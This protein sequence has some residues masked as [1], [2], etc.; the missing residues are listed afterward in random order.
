MPALFGS[1]LSS[2]HSLRYFFT[3]PIQASFYSILGLAQGKYARSAHERR[4]TVERLGPPFEEAV[5]TGASIRLLALFFVLFPLVA[6]GQS[7]SVSQNTGKTAGSHASAHQLE[8]KDYEQF[9]PYWT[10]EGS[11]LSELHLRNNLNAQD[12]V[13]TPSIRLAEG[14]EIG[15]QAVTIKPQEVK[16]IDVGTAAPQVGKAYGSIV[17]RYHSAFSDSVYASL[18]LHDLGH[19][20]AIHLDAIHA[21]ET[22]QGVS[23]E[24]VWWLPNETTNDYLVLTNQGSNPFKLDL[25]IYDAQGKESK[26]ALAL[27][28]RQTTRYSVRQLVQSAGFRG[29]YGGI[30]VVA[31]THAGSLDTVHFLFDE[32]AAFSALMKMFDQDPAAKIESRDFAR[33]GVWTQRA[34]MLALSQPDPALGFPAGTILQPQIFVRN[35]TSKPVTAALRFNW[36]SQSASGKATGPTLQLAPFETRQIDIAALQDGNGLPKEANWTSVTL[37]TKGK[38]DDLVAVAAS[39]DAT[40]LYGAQTPFSDQLSFRWEGGLWQYDAQHDSIITAGNGGTKPTQTAFTIFYNQGKDKYALEQ[41]LQPDEQMWIDVGKLIRERVLD[42]NGNTLPVDLAS[43]SYEFRDLNDPGVGSLFEGKVIYDKTYGHV[44]YGCAHCCGIQ[45]V[46][47]VYDPLG[48]PFQFTNQNGVLGDDACGDTG[49]RLSP[50]FYGNWSI[51]NTGIA[52]VNYYATHTGVA[53]GSTTSFTH[54]TLASPG[55]ASCPEN[56]HSTQGGANVCLAPTSENTSYYGAYQITEGTFEMTL[57]PG[58]NNYD[59]HYVTENNYA[60]GSDTC[61]WSTANP[62]IP[63]YPSVVGSTWTVGQSPAP[64]NGYGLDGIGLTSAGVNYIQTQ[65]GQ[66]GV[67][68]PCAL[69]WYQGMSY[70]CDANTFYSYAQNVLTQTIGSNTVNVCR[71]G[72][73]SGTIPF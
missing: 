24:G 47:P 40:L 14:T 58:T 38:P 42:K 35:T 21:D 54:A 62:G 59:T 30:K 44:T 67:N 53:V 37:T 72:K 3:Y 6:A 27:G 61:W 50:A 70:E 33:T 7:P 64:H 41:T 63:Q 19:P 32:Q 39:Y 56:V 17:L 13:V 48:V 49:L 1:S 65:A 16:T 51:A 69:T 60:Q 46:Y 4:P 12:L 23:R 15:L 28:A 36:R 10:T 20:I 73:C 45:S 57:N 25:S 5:M 71:A 2:P 43:G 52:T 26:Q 11:W 18:I 29:S 8:Y 34:P 9:V 66:H 31:K 68:F 22:L 55:R